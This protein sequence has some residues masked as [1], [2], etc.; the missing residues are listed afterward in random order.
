MSYSYYAADA[1]TQS[2]EALLEDVGSCSNSKVYRAA[3]TTAGNA[4]HRSASAK[5]LDSLSDPAVQSFP[6]LH[7]NRAAR[8]G[9]IIGIVQLILPLTRSNNATGVLVLCNRLSLWTCTLNG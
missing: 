1:P 7:V 6:A 4:V 8:T 2:L 5:F 9:T 3:D